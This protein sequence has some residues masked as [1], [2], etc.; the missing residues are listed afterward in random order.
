MLML[1]PSST[2]VCEIS[3]RPAKAV[4]GDGGGKAGDGGGNGGAMVVPSAGSEGFLDGPELAG[5]AVDAV[6]T[7]VGGN[8]P[9]DS[10][11]FGMTELSC[12]DLHEIAGDGEASMRLGEGRG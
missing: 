9:S 12:I 3:A 11:T 8:G 6:P 4:P 10:G 5:A 1:M 2:G 7:K